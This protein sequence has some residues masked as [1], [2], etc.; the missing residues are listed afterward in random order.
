MNYGNH[1]ARRSSLYVPLLFSGSA[2]PL[3][4][5]KQIRLYYRRKH[6]E[7]TYVTRSPAILCGMLLFF[8]MPIL[9]ILYRHHYQ[10]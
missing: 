6:Y 2:G 4:R 3:K 1:A 5:T 7:T 9:S 8:G 10:T